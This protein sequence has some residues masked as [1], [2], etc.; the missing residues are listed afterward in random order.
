MNVRNLT[1]LLSA[2]AL[3]AFGFVIWLGARAIEPLEGP[4]L[5]PHREPSRLEWDRPLGAQLESPTLADPARDPRNGQS[6]G[7]P[8]HPAVEAQ[9][10]TAFE[11]KYAGFSPEQ[12]KR[13]HDELTS[14]LVEIDRR[15]LKQRFET[16]ETRLDR[17]QSGENIKFSRDITAIPNGT[18]ARADAPIEAK[19]ADLD[20]STHPATRDLLAE[21]QWLG[22]RLSGHK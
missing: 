21:I 19:I 20:E 5:V 18:G 4:L 13:A 10:S 16:N 22:A 8:A 17:P 2:A 6:A 12:L 11:L 1:L 14:R 3:A 9:P 15:I 7:A